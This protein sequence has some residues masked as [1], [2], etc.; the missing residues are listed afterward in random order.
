MPIDQKR[1]N[2]PEASV[3]YDIYI[4]S[5]L[6]DNGIQSNGSKRQDGRS[7]NELRNIF[8]KAGIITE[9][10]GSAYIEMGN[11]KVV[12][13]VFDP[14]EI[15]NKTDYSVKGELYCEF[16]FAPFSHRKRKMHQQDAEEKEYSSILQRALEPAVCL[17][18]FPNFQIDIYTVV[19]DNGG[20]ALAAAITAASLALANA[21]VPMFGLVTAST[22][23][24]C[25][26]R[27][28]VDPT[29]AEEEF[30]STKSSSDASHNHGTIV[31]AIL[32]QH[33]QTSE[34]FV[35][36]N[37]DVDT[38]V[39]SIDL[40]SEAHKNIC[41]SVEQCLVKSVFKAFHPNIKKREKK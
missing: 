10:K 39:H 35:T 26:D 8:L 32:P 30:C 31:Q 20:S 6:K 21:G 24:I 16:K 27:Y 15:P 28:L 40:L 17:Q 1:I 3:P 4:H 38:I 37:I 12:C 11:T 36:G 29:D 41:L 13:S 19:L 23:G 7:N 25:D 22:I 5:E 9:A 18:E 2:G 33:G 34:M 14:R